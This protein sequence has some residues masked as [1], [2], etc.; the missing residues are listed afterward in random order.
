M[1]RRRHHRR[2]VE[3]H[4]EIT[5]PIT[6]MLDMSFQLL[7]FFILTFHPPSAAEGQM[8]I[9][10]PAMGAAKAK[11]PEQVDPFAQSD[12]DPEGE[13]QVTVVIESAA[14]LID[15]LTLREKE[16][17]T[18]VGDVKALKVELDKIYQQLGPEHSANIKVEA[19]SK[20]KYA[21]L[22]EVMDACLQAKF[23]SVGFAPPPDL[24]RKQ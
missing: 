15:K 13:A 21:F 9:F 16:K 7:S 14:G 5:L 3:E 17:N 23:K 8:D 24:S 12:K 6:P 2:D 18:P 11:A 19:D 22:V 20:L 4:V 1:P 10:L